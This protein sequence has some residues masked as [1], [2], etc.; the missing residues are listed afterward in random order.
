[1]P[2]L[3]QLLIPQFDNGGNPF[4]RSLFATTRE[5]LV[6]RFGGLTAYVRAPARGV[7]K[8]DDG[9]IVR[10]DIVIFEVMTDELDR[11]WWSGYRRTLEERFEQEALIARTMA[12]ETL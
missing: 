10:D 11:P 3:V 6:A 12:V 8:E 9:T 2:Y 7:W 5:E 4:A 1:M